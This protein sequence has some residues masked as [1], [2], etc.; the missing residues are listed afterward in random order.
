M[1]VPLKYGLGALLRD[2]SHD[3]TVWRQLSGFGLVARKPYREPELTQAMNKK[4]LERETFEKDE[5]VFKIM[6]EKPKFVRK[7]P[8]EEYYPDCIVPTV[9]HATSIM[10]WSARNFRG[11]GRL[12]VVPGAYIVEPLCLFLKS[13]VRKIMI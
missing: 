11:T 12:Q 13:F 5:S 9:K 8:G 10:V 4:R 1:G 3:R 2:V 6:V 7:R